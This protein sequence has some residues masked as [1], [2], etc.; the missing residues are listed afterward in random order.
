MEEVGC[1]EYGIWEFLYRWVLEW[2]EVK[3]SGEE[4]LGMFVCVCIV[5][6]FRYDGRE[7]YFLGIGL[8]F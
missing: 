1:G 5:E 4:G 7:C 6:F 2:L 3:S 8:V